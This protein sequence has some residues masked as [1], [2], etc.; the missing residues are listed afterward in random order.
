MDVFLKLTNRCIYP[1]EEPFEAL[2]IFQEL[3]NFCPFVEFQ[4]LENVCISN[5]ET[6]SRTKEAF[7]GL[8]NV[9]TPGTK[10]VVR[11]P[12]IS[13]TGNFLFFFTFYKT[14]GL[15]CLHYMN[16]IIL[17]SLQEPFQKHNI[18]FRNS[19]YEHFLHRNLL[20]TLGFFS[21]F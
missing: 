7:Q 20:K 10:N 4:G 17:F 13:G 2:R 12:T 19:K 15:L 18:F 9:F 16:V 21:Q 6:F 1:P 11:N 14:L 3:R 5:T 8:K